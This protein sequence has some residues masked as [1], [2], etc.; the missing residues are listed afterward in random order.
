[1]IA[2]KTNIVNSIHSSRESVRCSGS[3]ASNKARHSLSDAVEA[4]E[5]VFLYTNVK[6]TVSS[7]KG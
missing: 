3:R 6:K 5:L 7:G 4:T 2:V 1:M